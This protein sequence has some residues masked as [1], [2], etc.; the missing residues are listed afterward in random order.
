MAGD[1]GNVGVRSSPKAGLPSGWKGALGIVSGFLILILGLQL[2]VGLLCMSL[3]RP[4]FYS[5]EPDSWRLVLLSFA[6]LSLGTGGA[7]F[8]QTLAMIRGKNSKLLRLPPGWQLIGVFI[9]YAL[10]GRSFLQNSP[11]LFIFLPILLLTTALPS[12]AALSWFSE[13]RPNGI[14]WRQGSMVFTSSGFFSLFSLILGQFLLIGAASLGWLDLSGLISYS[15]P[16]TSG[17][18]LANLPAGTVIGTYLALTLIIELVKPL[19]ILPW[20]NTLTPRK[21]FFI[22]TIAG[23]G[24][25]PI[26]TLFYLLS[27]G[28]DY[29]WPT[30]IILGFGGAAYPL[31]AGLA[32]LAWYHLLKKQPREWPSGLAYWGVAGGVYLLWNTGFLFVLLPGYFS[33]GLSRWWGVLRYS[34]LPGIGLTGMIFLGL[35]FWW[36]GYSLL[37]RWEQAAEDQPVGS[38]LQPDQATAIWAAACFLGIFPLGLLGLYLFP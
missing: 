11:F 7:L 1:S 13:S 8:W 37:Q 35:I 30:M 2:G 29:W 33:F 32:S 9:L 15:A 19:L 34:V 16:L 24:F 20:L 21:A 36:A 31:S 22:G 10:F 12:L 26:A 17:P 27:V 4:W 38:S 25:A 14:T 18:L 5:S 3:S 28:W 23:A 6:I